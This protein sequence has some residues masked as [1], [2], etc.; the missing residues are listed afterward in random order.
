MSFLDRVKECNHHDLSR[1][2]PLYIGEHRVGW[3]RDDR[4]ALLSDYPD[5]FRLT[6]QSV[7]LN[8]DLDTFESRSIG[9]KPVLEE[10]RDQGAIP[11]WRDEPYPVTTSFGSPP[12]LQM[13]RAAFPCL[14][15][16]AYGIH[17][18]GVVHDGETVK[19]WVARRALDKPTFPGMLDNMVAG[20]MPIGIS[21]RDNLIK[22]CGEEAGIPPE[23]ARK[24]VYT[25]IISYCKQVP[26][27]LKPDVQFCC[28][29]E[30][31]VSFQPRAVD[32]EVEAFYLW[33]I[34]EVMRIVRD[35]AEFK[36]NCNLVIIDF[37]VRH[38]FI[39]PENRD[40]FEIARGLRQ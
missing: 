2:R 19:M 26:E 17:M 32:G 3:V 13:E 14:G 10:L 39:S 15:I 18:N 23:L 7:M 6:E 29:L 21:L 25:G 27:G 33:P 8:P 37:L 4:A 35:T 16:R 38:G 9:V 40:Y 11:A 24:A 34:E 22:E 28:D 12:L 1:F 31:P 36:F 20:G 5:V 30:L